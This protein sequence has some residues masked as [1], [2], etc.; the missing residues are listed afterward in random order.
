MIGPYTAVMQ[1]ATLFCLLICVA[2]T[3]RAFKGL[4]VLEVLLFSL[5]PQR[6]RTKADL[7]SEPGLR[8]ECIVSSQA[9]IVRSSCMAIN[10]TYCIAYYPVS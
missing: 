2:E 9:A 6:P 7:T 4:V 10:Y 8:N 5:H 1:P 3:S